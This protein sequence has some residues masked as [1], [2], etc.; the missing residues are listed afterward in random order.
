MDGG[1]SKGAR[2]LDAIYP[3]SHFVG[4]RPPTI[5]NEL[6]PGDEM[7]RRFHHSFAFIAGLC[8]LD[9]VWWSRQKARQA[10]Q[11][12]ASSQNGN[13]NGNGNG[14]DDDD[15]NKQPQKQQ[16]AP[17]DVAL[18]PHSNTGDALLGLWI[19]I[20]AM[21][22]SVVASFAI[23]AWIALIARTHY[24]REYSAPIILG[25]FGTETILVFAMPGSPPA[26]PAAI[27]LGN[28]L[29]SIIA[30]AIQTGFERQ[31]SFM[32][33]SV[34][35]VNWAAP[36]VALITS[37]AVMQLIGIVHPPGAAI[38]VLA[39]TTPNVVN[40]R[41]Q[42]CGHV[43]LISLLFVAW[44]MIVNNV[45]SRRW[46]T[47][48]FLPFYPVPKPRPASADHPKPWRVREERVFQYNKY[49]DA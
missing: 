4:H 23:L 19:R 49:A 15:S 45:G 2:F 1:R 12:R 40:Q 36:N 30:V 31:S 43:F 26:Q 42:L 25:A 39:T 13:G 16:R 22:H 37:L 41:W 34:E 35:G 9:P 28:T 10:H 20:T 11:R 47:N 38:C 17:E 3:A 5:E 8:W 33:Q 21:I 29:S 24:W 48:W 44:A 18:G 46:P 14:H 32:P 7:Y 6:S 27:I